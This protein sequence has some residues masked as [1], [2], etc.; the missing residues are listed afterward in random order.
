MNT[1][2]PDELLAAYV[3]GTLGDSERARVEQAIAQDARLAQRVA[4]QRALRG[5]LRNVFDGVLSETLPA[6]LA[7]AGRLDG[8][9]GPAQIIDLARVRAERARRTERRRIAIPRRAA[10]T[11]AASLL[12]G[13]GVGLLG[14]RLFDSPGLTEYR[15][16]SLFASGP[17]NRALN[18][19]LA[20]SGAGPSAVRIGFS[21][22]S[23][24]GSYCRTFMLDNN[25]AL[26]G[27]ACHEPQGWR[28]L[29]LLGTD[30]NTPS[31]ATSR[32]AGYAMPPALLQSVD[33]RI[34]G[35]PL[36]TAT[37]LKTRRSGWH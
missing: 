34:S 26:N 7:S 32:M 21:F 27:L 25:H 29:A 14:E 1:H 28:V 6:R 31:S 22:R 13:V 12:V 37:E 3:D 30:S 11:V 23:K 18:E 2:F 35:A 8:S 17:L 36:D 16:G 4:Q 15:D 20:S 9:S 33:D 5:R 10:L 24:S 19:Q